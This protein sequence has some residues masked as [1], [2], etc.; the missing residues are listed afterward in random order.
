[1]L[2]RSQCHKSYIHIKGTINTPVNSKGKGDKGNIRASRQFRISGK[3][4]EDL[5]VIF[6]LNEG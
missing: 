3:H 2:I 6:Y 1:M 5:V 4:I